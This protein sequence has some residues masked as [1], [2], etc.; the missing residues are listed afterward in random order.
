MRFE[1]KPCP[2][3]GYRSG[4]PM[5]DRDFIRSNSVDIEFSVVKAICP[6]CGWE[7]RNHNNVEECELVIISS[8][9]RV[10]HAALPDFLIKRFN[11]FIIQ[12]YQFEE[13][14]LMPLYYNHILFALLF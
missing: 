14:R 5:F 1:F 3:C 11:E 8:R 12:F 9:L 10:P 13:C 4:Y 7:T 2:D 6:V